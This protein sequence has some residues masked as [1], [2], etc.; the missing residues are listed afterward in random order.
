MSENLKYINFKGEAVTLWLNPNDNLWRSSDGT[1][2]AFRDDKFSVDPESR[3]GVGR[4]SLPKGNTLNELCAVHDT[5]Y[6]NPAYQAFHSRLEADRSLYNLIEIKGGK[7]SWLAT[8][9]FYL[10]R[11]FG[12]QYW[13]DSKTR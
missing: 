9:F 12:G 3:C 13:E 2:W 4:F 5:E 8:P 7:W 1:V 10:C 11:L 6:S